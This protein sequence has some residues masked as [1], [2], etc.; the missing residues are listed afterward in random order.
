MGDAPASVPGAL[1]GKRRRVVGSTPNAWLWLAR[2]LWVT[3]P[4]QTRGRQTTGGPIAWRSL[5]I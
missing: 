2:K 1:V 3:I 4:R 5:P